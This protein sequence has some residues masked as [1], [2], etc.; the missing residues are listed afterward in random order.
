MPVV[1]KNNLASYLF[2]RFFYLLLKETNFREPARTLPQDEVES[3]SL[4]YYNPEIH[5]A[6]FILPEFA[7]K[8]IQ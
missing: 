2:L 5:K 4:R 1:S 8:V 7:R 6:S 3:M